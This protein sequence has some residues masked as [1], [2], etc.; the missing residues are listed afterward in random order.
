MRIDYEEALALTEINSTE[1]LKRIRTIAED[2]YIPAIS[3]LGDCYLTGHYVEVD[4]SSAL[5]WYSRAAACEDAHSQR[6]IGTMYLTGKGVSENHNT[7]FDWFELAAENGDMLGQFYSAQLLYGGLGVVAN[8]VDA[9]KWYILAADQGHGESCLK[10]GDIYAEGTDGIQKDESKAIRYYQLATKYGVEEARSKYEELYKCELEVRIGKTISKGLT[11]SQLREFDLITDKIEAG[12][13]LDENKPDYRNIVKDIIREMEYDFPIIKYDSKKYQKPK[14]EYE[15]IKGVFG[16][17]RND[18]PEGM[19]SCGFEI[20]RNSINTIGNSIQTY[21]HELQNSFNNC[22]TELLNNAH[23]TNRHDSTPIMF[24]YL[25]HIPM[26]GSIPVIAEEGFVR[27]TRF[28]GSVEKVNGYFFDRGYLISDKEH[29]IEYMQIEPKTQSIQLK[30]SY[31]FL[32]S[33]DLETKDD[34]DELLR[35]IN[36]KTNLLIIAN[37]YSEEALMAILQNS[38][39]ITCAAVKAPSIGDRRKA[40]LED[41]SVLTGANI[42]TTSASTESKST[43]KDA[44]LGYAE[45]III[46]PELTILAGCLASEELINKRINQLYREYNNTVSEFDKGKLK[47]RIQKLSNGVLIQRDT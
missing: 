26:M 14:A 47:E 9:V 37:N 6:M 20:T 45:H 33:L 44:C 21:L 12:K 46:Q 2:G 17:H 23:I 24:S 7:A 30:C 3:F 39:G 43:L 1:G 35:V 13:W 32:T 19:L 41:I 27:G 18:S 34:V 29:L 22:Q 25:E 36:P 5:Q 31:I 42:M 4:Y 16:K 40:M 28:E 15:D 11:Q 8:K 38:L 10:L